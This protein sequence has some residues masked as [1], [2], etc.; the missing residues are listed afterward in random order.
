[1]RGPAKQ[2]FSAVIDRDDLADFDRAVM[3][4]L[5]DR[6]DEALPVYQ[7]MAEATKA[8]SADKKSYTLDGLVY[9]IAGHQFAGKPD[10]A[11]EW[12]RKLIAAAPGAA[13]VAN[14]DSA[15]MTPEH[16]AVMKKVLAATLAKHPEL[17][18]AQ[19]SQ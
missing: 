9:L 16:V 11:I 4:A 17:A 14:L 2:E 15:G 3:L 19:E 12:Y 8:K 13:V 7:E 6:G 18:P 5:L 10:I 1:M